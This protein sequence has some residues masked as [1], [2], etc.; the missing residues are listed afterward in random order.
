MGALALVFSAAIGILK[1]FLAGI[2]GLWA[3]FNAYV[4]IFP[5]H[6]VYARAIYPY[7]LVFVLFIVC[8]HCIV[9]YW[10]TKRIDFCALNN[11]NRLN[12]STGD[13]RKLFS[14]ERDKNFVIPFNDYF[15]TELDE[16]ISTRSVHGQFL[17]WVYENHEPRALNRWMAGQLKNFS[18][19]EVPEKVQ[20]KSR[21]YVREARACIKIEDNFFY[22]LSF[23]ST[24][25]ANLN[26][27]MNWT[28]YASAIERMC[29]F[30]R[31]AGNGRK[32]F[33]PLV[34]DQLGRTGMPTEVL[35]QL[36][37]TGIWRSDKFEPIGSSIELVLY[38]KH[39]HKFD[40]R[41]IRNWGGSL[42]LS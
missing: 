26:A 16:V 27:S 32:C 2:G 7:A 1:N 42:G 13:L 39:Q 30:L 21:K 40:L 10:P 28:E 18:G 4:L 29:K 19:E 6:E 12:V 25:P 9:I 34:G 24:D 33:V 17:E 3:V 31:E 23:G 36:L 11:G 14:S 8:I 20:G 22:L 37:L 35:V 41:R 15:D 5:G 38:S